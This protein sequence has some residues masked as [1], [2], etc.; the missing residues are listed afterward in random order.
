MNI[1]NAFCN[2][3]LKMIKEVRRVKNLKLEI[4]KDNLYTYD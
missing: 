1:K 2:L 4:V 3:I